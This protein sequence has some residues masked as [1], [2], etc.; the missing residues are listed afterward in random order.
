MSAQVTQATMMLADGS[1]QPLPSMHVR[2]TEYTVGSSGP[3]AMPGQLPQTSAYTYA[4]D[5]TADEALAAG[6]VAITF[7]KPAISYNENF[8]GFPVG[9]TVPAGHYDPGAGLWAPDDNGRV[10]K[11]LGVSGGLASL[12]VDGNNL[13]ATQ[14]ELDALGITNAELQQLAALYTTGQ[15]LWRVPTSHFTPWDMNWPYGP[16]TDT[17][18]PKLPWYNNEQRGKI[19]AR[20]AVRSLTART[21]R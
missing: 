17:I 12:D 2:A 20:R 13:P 11:I 10:V 1:S 18:H 6:A 19:P 8:L 3:Q 14:Q 16:P 4:S 7:T 5:F 15:T 9:T 21:S